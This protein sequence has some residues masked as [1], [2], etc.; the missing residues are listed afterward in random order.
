MNS[1][2]ACDQLPDEYPGKT[3]AEIPELRDH[4]EELSTD[5]KRWIT[6]FRCKDCGMI[7]EERYEAKGH[8]DAPSV[9]KV[10]T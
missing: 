7:W 4:V 3:L 6:V 8:G 1:E 2:K 9:R 10:K 5:F